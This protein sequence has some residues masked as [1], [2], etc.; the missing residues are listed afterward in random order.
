MTAIDNTPINEN[1]LSPLNFAFTIKKTPNVN[2]FVQEAI[3]PALKLPSTH[4][5][6]PFV[7]IPL[8]GEHLKFDPLR[9]TFKIDEDLKGY[10]EIFNWL[11][12]LGKPDNYGQYFQ[13]EKA[14]QFAGDG[15]KSDLSLILMS[16][17]KNPHIEF[18]FT[19]AFPTS[20]SSLRLNVTKEGITYI[21]VIATFDYTL[22]TLNKII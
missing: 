11:T 22:F 18:V 16:N 3:I 10:M 17:I 7:N 19:D 13:I 15:I 8:P 2:F 9:I 1:Y 20:L 4:M 6:N 21:T 12:A 14:N 5:P